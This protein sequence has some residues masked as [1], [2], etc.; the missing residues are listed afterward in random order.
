MGERL[1]YFLFLEIYQNSKA[2]T[3]ANGQISL[4]EIGEVFIIYTA[5]DKNGNQT[6]VM[7]MINIVG[8]EAPTPNE[9]GC[10]SGCNSSFESNLIVAF[11]VVMYATFIY[12]RK[13]G[14]RNVK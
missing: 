12:L 10:K 14:K 3:P 13:G 8:G 9:S 5:Q 11:I 4:S 2:I 7:K 6:A 1:I